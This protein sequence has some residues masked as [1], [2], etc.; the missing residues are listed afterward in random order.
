MHQA[1]VHGLQTLYCGNVVGDQLVQVTG[2]GVRL[3]SASS[4][5]LLDQWTPPAGLQVNTAS[6]S[7]SQV[8]NPLLASVTTETLLLLKPYALQLQIHAPAYAILSGYVCKASWC[9]AVVCEL[10]KYFSGRWHTTQTPQLLQV[11]LPCHQGCL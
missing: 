2:A 6:A 1:G 3:L 11:L 7:P 10:V 8:H 4:G 5:A 9:L